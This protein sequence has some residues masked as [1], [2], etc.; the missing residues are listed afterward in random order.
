MLAKLVTVKQYSAHRCVN[1]RL[2]LGN[3]HFQS[4][5]VF[6]LQSPSFFNGV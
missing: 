1:A 6:K 4:F 2:T 3:Q 5:W